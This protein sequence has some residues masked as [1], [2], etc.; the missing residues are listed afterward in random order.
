MLE[1]RSERIEEQKLARE[2]RIEEQRRRNRELE[3]RKK[4]QTSKTGKK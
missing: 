3:E 2:A 1:Q 4:S